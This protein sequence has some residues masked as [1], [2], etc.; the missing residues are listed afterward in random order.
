M[1]NVKLFKPGEIQGSEVDYF[2]FD[3]ELISKYDKIRDNLKAFYTYVS[4]SKHA[5]IV[6]DKGNI[7]SGYNITNA[8]KDSYTTPFSPLTPAVIAQAKSKRNQDLIKL[9]GE[10]PVASEHDNFK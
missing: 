1:A 10:N 5:T 8:K 7:L 2:I 4:R 9:L 3:A 6:V